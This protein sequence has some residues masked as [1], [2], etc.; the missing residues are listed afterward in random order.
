[1]ASCYHDLTL[2]QKFVI[3]TNVLLHLVSFLL[4]LGYF[5]V[6]SIEKYLEKQTII[7]T[8]EEQTNGIR[9]PAVTIFATKNSLLGWKTL[10][11]SIIE[12]ITSF[13]QALTGFRLVPNFFF[14]VLDLSRPEN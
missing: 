1:M 4:F 2:R 6:P 11:Q 5:G 9:A 3:G 8:S 10:D 12:D 13:D 7:V 14:Q